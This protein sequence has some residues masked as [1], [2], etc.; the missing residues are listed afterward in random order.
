MKFA[1]LSTFAALVLSQS[2]FAEPKHPSYVSNEPMTQEACVEKI[3]NFAMLWGLTLEVWGE[4]DFY[5]MDGAGHTG[6][7]RYS[8]GICHIDLD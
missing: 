7:A 8:M 1:L 2:S 6:N 3:Q 4:A 5:L